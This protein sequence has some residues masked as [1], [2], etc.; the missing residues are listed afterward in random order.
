MRPTGTFTW[1]APAR[2]WLVSGNITQAPIDA[3]ERLDNFF[4]TAEGAT[5]RKGCTKHATIDATGVR[6]FQWVSGDASALFAATASDIFEISSPADADTAPTATLTGLGSGDWSSVQFGVSGGEYTIAVN[7]T[8]DAV[9]YDG[10]DL[11]PITSVAV[12]D[13]GYDAQTGA[14]TVGQ[15]VTGGTSGATAEILAIAPTSA[16]AGTLKLGT[17]TGTFQDNEA[18]TDPITGAATANGTASVGSSLT[19]TGQGTDTFSQVFTHKQRVFFIEKGTLSAWY[20]PAASIAGAATELNLSGVFSEG[21]SLLFGANWSLDSGSGLDDKAVF[22]TDQGE[23]AVYSGTDPSSASTWSLDGVY[24]I[25]PPVDKHGHFALGG[26]LMLVTQDGIVPVSQAVSRDYQ[27][28][29]AG[30]LSAPIEDEWQRRISQASSSEPVAVAHWR[31]R[32]Q[33]FVSVPGKVEGLAQTFV[34]NSRIK[35]WCRYLGW[36]INAAVVFE[37]QFYFADRSGVVFRGEI[38]GTDNGTAYSGYLVPKFSDMGTPDNKFANHVGLVARAT[39]QVTW[40][41][42]VFRNYATKA[43][44][45]PATLPTP[46]SDATWGTG[47]WGT[48]VWGG[49]D[50]ELIGQQRWKTAGGSGFA[51]APAIAVTSNSTA[52][53]RVDVTALRMRYEVGS[54]L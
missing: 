32:G 40:S 29:V 5:L 19:I 28:V 52:A 26:D 48:S 35:A 20:L 8:D 4:P 24:R 12:N 51:L 43:I 45:A 42:S 3:A 1:P 13:L 53:P 16:T 38:G 18:L 50:D 36:T 41:A 25:G 27:A 9:I 49:S 14:F 34:A 31:S 21:G 37:D 30:A 2:G 23:V 54:V 47:V 46:P 22:V 15:T 17:I 11:N 44:T 7:G 39:V 33:V 6:F 10:T